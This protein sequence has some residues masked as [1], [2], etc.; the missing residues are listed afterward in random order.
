MNQTTARTLLRAVALTAACFAA[1]CS[2]SQLGLV[3]DTATGENPAVDSMAS[4]TTG[5]DST[6]SDSSSSDRTGTDLNGPD[7]N[8]SDTTA[9]AAAV[10]D[11]PPPAGPRLSV[12]PTEPFL[13]G[14][15]YQPVFFGSEP[16]RVDCAEP[17]RIEVYG[18]HRL[19]GDRDA[20]LPPAELVARL[21]DGDF[22]ATTGVS[23]DLQLV[24]NRLVIRPSEVTWAQGEREVICYVVY[25]E[26]TDRLL[27]Q[28]NPLRSLGLVSIHGLRSGDCLADFD[29]AGTRF[30]LVDCFNA[31]EAEVF[32]A[33]EL[34]AGPFPGA[35]V[36]DP[37]ADDRCFGNGFISFVG[38]SYPESEVEALK[39]VPNEATWALG[40]RV[41][42]C[43]ATDGL[44]R[45]E[46]LAGI[47]R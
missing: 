11:G 24:L 46:S 40:H 19:S 7:G 35:A 47:G 15:C 4:D 2:V 23:A 5:P 38:L 9:G 36:I 29:P 45:Y 3:E 6:G 33:V 27:N 34:P 37:L 20:E 10:D 31:H 32:A 16:E 12:D 44:L 42:A 41:I 8:D 18:T 17:H 14:A 26:P 13:P 1:G 25:P 39:S 21:C 22:L 43:I 28:I 30:R